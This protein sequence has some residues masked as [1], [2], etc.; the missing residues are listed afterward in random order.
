[1]YEYRARYVGNYDGD[2]IDLE[3]DLGFN[4]RHT[5]RV[6]L[7]DVNTPELRGGTKE[8]KELA[9]EARDFVE[10]TLGNDHELIVRTE[11]DRKGKYG[12]YIARIEVDGEFDLGEELLKLGLATKYEE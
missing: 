1:M 11:K 7:A 12:R 5:I 2:T 4:I 8:S 3:V 9:I 10:E 6:R